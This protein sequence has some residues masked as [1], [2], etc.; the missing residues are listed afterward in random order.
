[1]WRAPQEP[2]FFDPSALV[3]PVTSAR[4]FTY[5]NNRLADE[6]RSLRVGVGKLGSVPLEQ[7][8]RT[9]QGNPWR[10]FAASLDRSAAFVGRERTHRTASEQGHSVTLV[11]RDRDPSVDAVEVAEV[12]LRRMSR[13][14]QDDKKPGRRQRTTSKRDNERCS[15]SHKEP[16]V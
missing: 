6:D 2:S 4:T 7:A 3:E 8:L 16:P 12:H 9:R 14:R 1:M 10:W 13:G 5:A 15:G 11:P